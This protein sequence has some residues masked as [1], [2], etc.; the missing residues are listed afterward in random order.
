MTN[1]EKPTGKSDVI[2]KTVLVLGAGIYQIP[3]IKQLRKL[4]ARVAVAS[5][6]GDYPGI[7]FADDFFPIDT[8]DQEAL[9]EL[10]QHLEVVGVCTTGTDV[11]M[12]SVG[13][14]CDA[15]NLQG[16]TQNMAQ[17]ATNKALMKR[18][19][20]DGGARTPRAIEVH[21]SGEALMAASRLGF[22]VMVKCVDK[23]GSRGITRVCNT[24]QM[25]EAFDCAWSYS[26]SETI[27]VE[28]CVEGHE[29][30]VD[31]YVNSQGDVV[32]L[33][34]HD[35]VMFSNGI[36]SVPVG[37]RLNESF[38]EKCNSCTD[39]VQQVKAAIVALGMKQCFFNMD[40]M[41][42]DDLA[43]VIEA[44]VR[45]GATCIPEV[46]SEFY[47]FD[48]YGKIAESAIGIDPQFDDAEI[49][50]KRAVEGRLLF[51]ET[52]AVCTRKLSEEF[53]DAKA[54]LDV[55]PGES[56]LPFKNGTNRYGQIVACG[57]DADL[58]SA[59]IDEIAAAI[60][61]DCFASL[62]VN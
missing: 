5:I 59:R 48:Y 17:V 1:K 39:I 56:V 2:G 20:I 31:G 43:Y 28:E 24:S 49:P 53:S 52:G 46:I 7:A 3:L 21:N 11:A 44:G 54:S 15:L 8:T 18:A 29:I 23:S 50:A 27:L 25:Q 34:P 60:D 51:S 16:P 47:G 14:I 6:P 45:C 33:A 26:D 38:L 55:I 4:G 40:V 57:S 9:L 13:Y 35:K 32:F 42:R 30:G 10:A 58:L 19:F 22:P 61:A 62:N 36:Y 37:H 12:E 41:L